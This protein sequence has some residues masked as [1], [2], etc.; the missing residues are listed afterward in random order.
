MELTI[1]QVYLYQRDGDGK[2]ETLAVRMAGDLPAWYLFTTVEKAMDFQKNWSVA[3][4][5]AKGHDQL[6]AFL[7]AADKNHLMARDP[8]PTADSCYCIKAGDLLDAVIA[9]KS[10]AEF[11][12]RKLEP[13]WYVTALAPEALRGKEK[14]AYR[15]HGTPRAG[16]G[17]R[18]G[19]PEAAS[20][21][22]EE[23]F[24][25]ESQADAEKFVEYT[26]KF[27]DEWPD[28]CQG[29]AYRLRI[30]LPSIRRALVE[31]TGTIGSKKPS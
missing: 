7:R 22:E 21:G 3:W 11:E 14:T 27:F 9:G 2:E 17:E 26:A 31:R 28:T 12:R 1:P 29:D 30:H 23:T 24:L 4:G 19:R 8:V 20:G 5:I 6:M 16:K 18:I 13:C 15:W 25:F 10:T